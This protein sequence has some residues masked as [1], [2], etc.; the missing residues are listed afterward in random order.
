M[1]VAKFVEQAGA[2]LR[3]STVKIVRAALPWNY[4]TSAFL[5]CDYRCLIIFQEVSVCM[6][7]K[8]LLV[9][10]RTML[11]SPLTLA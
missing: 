6:R 1:Y 8:I 2:D 5:V 4:C 3:Y 10:M 7:T 9:H 11:L